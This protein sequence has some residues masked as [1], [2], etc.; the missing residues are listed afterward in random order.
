MSVLGL[1]PR[2]N[3]E[4]SGMDH[5]PTKYQRC[6]NDRKCPTREVTR[7][8]AQ[9]PEHL[10]SFCQ[11]FQAFKDEMGGMIPVKVMTSLSV[12]WM[13]EHLPH[14]WKKKEC[15]EDDAI[16]MTW[17]QTLRDMLKPESHLVWM[18]QDCVCMLLT[19]PFVFRTYGQEWLTHLESRPISV[20]YKVPWELTHL[21][22]DT[23]I[24]LFSRDSVLRAF[25]V[26]SLETTFQFLCQLVEQC[27][28]CSAWNDPLQ[29]KNQMMK[30][31]VP[32]IAFL[33]SGRLNALV[34]NHMNSN[35][36][37]LFRLI[38]ETCHPATVSVVF[39]CCV[40]VFGKRFVSSLHAYCK[41]QYSTYSKRVYFLETPNLIEAFAQFFVPQFV[42]SPSTVDIKTEFV[43]EL[44]PYQ[45]K[46]F[47]ESVHTCFYHLYVS[48]LLE[49]IAQI[50]RI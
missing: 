49:E 35:F 40:H 2:S 14:V 42:S 21:P 12:R 26:H 33:K 36:L 34:D 5:R 20:S 11:A 15:S 3:D 32:A 19:N 41:H 9:L 37:L 47:T 8:E 38:L 43:K 10:K 44:L 48:Y 1:H 4:N 24:Q 39:E 23:L 46:S 30:R 6:N 29:F 28:R 45:S 22:E 13:Q 50:P 16:M 17:I 18:I 31:Q 7:A 27:M 25:G